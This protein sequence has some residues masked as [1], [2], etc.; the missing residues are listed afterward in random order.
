MYSFKFS[1]DIDSI[2]RVLISSNNI[3][4]NFLSDDDIKDFRVPI[5]NNVSYIE[6]TYDKLLLGYFFLIDRGKYQE[7]HMAFLPSAYG[8]VKQAGI[9]CVKW[10]WK[11][12]NARILLAPCISTNKLAL[13]CI[14]AFG[15]L[16]WAKQH[17]AWTRNGIS[18]DYV[19]LMLEY[20]NI[21]E[22]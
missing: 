2:R 14:R 3:P 17:N 10:V 21:D 6:V 5:L 20:H 19:W 1:N 15:F 18:H 4:Y 22:V 8:K 9:E 12:T 7:C 16:P 13:R 11:N